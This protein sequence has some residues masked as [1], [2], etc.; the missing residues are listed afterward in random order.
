MKTSFVSILALASSFM[1]VMSAPTAEVSIEKRA[2]DPTTL[3]TSL[4][5]TVQVYT[6]QISK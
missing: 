3:V 1:G 5:A 4:L 6:A 2:S